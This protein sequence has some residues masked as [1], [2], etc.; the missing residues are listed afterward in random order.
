MNIVKNGVS[1]GSTSI[2]GVKL[3]DTLSFQMSGPA[4]IGTK[5]TATVTIGTDTYSWWVGYA[6]SSRTAKVFLSSAPTID[7]NRGGLSGLNNYCTTKAAASTMGLSS[8]WK[9]IASNS[10]T[11]AYENIPW[12][13]GTLKT[14][15]N[16]TVIDGGFSDL[17]DGSLD[18][19]LNVNEN[20][21]TV[22][23]GSVLT[24]TNYL[25]SKVYSSSNQ[26]AYCSDWTYGGGDQ[27]MRYGNVGSTNSAWIDYAY[28]YCGYGSSYYIYC[29]ENID[30]AS[31]TTPSPIVTPYKVQVATSSRQSSN[32][33]AIGGMSPAASATLSVTATGG[34]PKFKVNGGA[35]VSSASV[36]NGDSVVFVLDAPASGNASYKMTITANGSTTLGYWR[37]WTGDTTGTAVKRVFVT[38]S[39][40]NGSLGGVIGADA[41]CQS[42]AS[43]AALGGTWKAIISDKTDESNWAVNRIGYNWSTLRTV[44]GTDVMVA[45]QIWN[46]ASSPL[47]YPINKTQTGVI[48]SSAETYTNT[49]SAGA[50]KYTDGST[51]A[52]TN[53]TAGTNDWTG[54]YG[55][56][57]QTGV[58]WIEG[59]SIPS[60]GYPCSDGHRLYCIEQ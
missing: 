49:T 59:Y 43:G 11:N 4:V 33:V 23:S 42:S 53:Y 46:T 30:D 29:I 55:L 48:V 50:A 36:S 7:A 37:V 5:T 19:P 57:G 24:A 47:L 8:S 12:N 31:D 18:N 34:D 56:V 9:A 3:G 38:S 17:W 14:V 15:T 26:S 21:A 6:D 25:G 20:G 51:S 54:V 16:V 10:T 2:S 41:K 39:S 35:E 32:S 22:G 40:Y 13:W 58:Y 1:T 52:C 44:D 60:G 27:Q 28:S 45:G